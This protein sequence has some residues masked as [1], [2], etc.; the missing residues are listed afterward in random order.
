M[1]IKPKLDRAGQVGLLSSAMMAV[2]PSDFEWTKA[3]SDKIAILAD[4]LN[5]TFEIAGRSLVYILLYVSAYRQEIAVIDVPKILAQ[6]PIKWG[7]KK[8]RHDYLHLLQDLD[9]IFVKT[10]YWAKIRAKKYGVAPSG[11][12]LLFRV[13]EAIFDDRRM[14]RPDSTQ[15]RLKLA[16]GDG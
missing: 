5:T 6:F 7:Y 11:H 12:A 3:E 9:F 8:K 14:Q 13:V 10:D 15:N 2:L 4:R 1:G 16:A